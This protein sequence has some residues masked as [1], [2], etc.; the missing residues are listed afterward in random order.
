MSTAVLSKNSGYVFNIQRYSV[1][2]GPGIRTTVFLKGCPLDCRWCSNPESQDFAPELAYN[3][4]KCIGIQDCSWCKQACKF[5]AIRDSENGK[6]TIDREACQKC[7]Q[8][9]A[10]CPSKALHTFGSVMTVADVLKTVE[11]DSIFYARSGGGLTLSGGEPLAQGEFAY[12][13]IKEAKKRRVD[14]TIET[15]GFVDWSQLERVAPY[16]KIILFDLKSMN[17]D[18]HKEFTGVSNQLILENFVKLRNSFPNLHILVRTPVIPGFNDTDD[19]IAAIV[20]FIKDMPNVSYEIL[21][22]HRM[23]QQKYT[24][25]SREYRLQDVKLSEE[26]AVALKA[27]AQSLKGGN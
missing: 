24:Y 23:G 11:A 8:C 13:I 14:A 25:L 5:D 21:P 20:N 2:D 4:N 12:E 9:V 1:H 18:K 7:F 22:Y 15:C 16:L 26:R 3:D 19:D 17:D 27:L 6:V 10:V